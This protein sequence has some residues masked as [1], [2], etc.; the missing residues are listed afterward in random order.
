MKFQG[1]IT[2]ESLDK[3]LDEL[4]DCLQIRDKYRILIFGQGAKTKSFYKNLKLEKDIEV[5]W[6]GWLWS[7][8]TLILSFI[9]GQ[10]GLIRLKNTNR[11]KELYYEI[12]AQS[13]CALCFVDSK[14]ENE[15]L[16]RIAHKHKAKL[17][18]LIENSENSFILDVD[19]DYHSGARD[20][21]VV[22]KLAYLGYLHL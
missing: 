8:W 9:P 10:S 15:M 20:D 2:W 6:T 11:L 7:G 12:G 4:L 13:F 18:D 19:F 16:R 21:E 22:Y 1:K 3:I 14:T 17:S 5:L